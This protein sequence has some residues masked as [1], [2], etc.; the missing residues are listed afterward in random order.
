MFIAVGLDSI[1]IDLV[2]KFC[3][4]GHLPFINK[5]IHSGLFQELVSNTEVSSGSTW[6]TLN[7][8]LNPVKHGFTFSHRQFNS[9]TYAV[10]KMDAD[11]NNPK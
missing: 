11:T 6:A 10:V 9:G 7:T 5:V 3:A 8:G 4:T 1:E 2:K